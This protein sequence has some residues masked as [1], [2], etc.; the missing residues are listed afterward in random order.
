MKAHAER[1]KKASEQKERQSVRCVSGRVSTNITTARPITIH[2]KGK[3]SATG[4]TDGLS[5]RVP[6]H[7]DRDDN[8]NDNDHNAKAVNELE[9]E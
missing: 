8:H 4:R 1:L 7:R 2:V 3:D 5:R 9:K 6:V